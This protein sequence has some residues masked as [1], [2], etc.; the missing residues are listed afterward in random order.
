MEME[1]KGGILI[2]WRRGR[3]K[4]GESIYYGDGE[5]WKRGD[6]WYYRDGEEGKIFK[7]RSLERGQGGNFHI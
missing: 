7:Q 4:R 6:T 1:K 2:L 3:W 5:D